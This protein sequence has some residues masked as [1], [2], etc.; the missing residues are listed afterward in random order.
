MSFA[1]SRFIASL[2]LVVAFFG[3]SHTNQAYGQGY[4]FALNQGNPDLIMHSSGYNGTGGVL[5]ISVGIDPTSVF[6]AEMQISVQNVVN[7]WN[8]LS[9]TTGNVQFGVIGNSQMDFESVLL[10]E[11]GH[12]LGLAHVN[13]ASESGVSS[14]NQDYSNSSVG[15]NGVYDL[16]AGGDG[17][18]GSA[19]DI[20]G[21]DVNY[22]FFESGVNNP[23]SV[24]AIVDSTTYSNNLADLPA[25]E[26]YVANADRDVSVLYGVA[27][28][29]G[30]MQQ[31]SFFGEIQRTLA[32]SDVI[33]IRY[34]MSGL[35]EIQGTSDDYILNL[36][37]AG[38]DAGADIVIDFDNAQTGFAVSQSSFGSI[39][40]DHWSINSSSIF[41]NT[42]TNWF[43][44]QSLAIP[45]PGSV[46]LI[47]L[48]TTG[49]MLRRRRPLA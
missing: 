34:A 42:G 39:N 40:P 45:E 9:A 25:G 35:D 1:N 20:R 33:G 44:N 43:F 47:A 24:N 16:N 8:G 2:T 36:Q 18:I 15:I 22:N 46:A 32:G 3:I 19:D 48:A 30:V 14:G 12:S 11:M 29:E 38:L 5:N 28:T 21:D 7:T 6:A 10:H 23:F 13:L 31:G 41:F 37:F 49:L 17:I 4:I 26:T 27:D